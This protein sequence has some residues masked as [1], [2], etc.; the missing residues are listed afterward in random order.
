ML[1]VGVETEIYYYPVTE[2]LN[3]SVLFGSA[4]ID[5]Y[6]VPAYHGQMLVLRLI[7]SIGYVPALLLVAVVF[8]AWVF[9]A[10]KIYQTQSASPF[11]RSLAYYLALFFIVE[12]TI[13]IVGNLNMIK[14]VM[15]TNIMP[16]STNG[17]LWVLFVAFLYACYKV[18]N[19][20]ALN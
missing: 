20:K 2:N 8:A 6:D 4:N 11:W 14:N 17:A 1:F 16:F 19:N 15:A 12:T 3:S 18:V 7:H 9:A 10:V 13:N 5:W